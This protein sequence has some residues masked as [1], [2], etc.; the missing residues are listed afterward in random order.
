MWMQEWMC[1]STQASSSSG[2]FQPLCI[3]NLQILWIWSDKMLYNS[4]VI[5][6]VMKML[7]S[8]MRSLKTISQLLDNCTPWLLVWIMYV[9]RIFHRIKRKIE[10]KEKENLVFLTGYKLIV[11]V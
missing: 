1:E 6:A 10:E 7:F 8:C 3:F 9:K 5:V 4:F 11:I 2:S